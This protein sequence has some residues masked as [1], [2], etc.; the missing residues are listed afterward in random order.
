MAGY[1]NRVITKHFPELVEPGDDVWVTIRNPRLMPPGEL[2]S[3]ADDVET[4]PDGQP[5]NTGTAMKA[6]YRVGAKIIIGMRVYDPTA[7]IEL[8]DHGEPLPGGDEALLPA[9]PGP[10]DVAKLPLAIINWLGDEMAKINP[11]QTPESPGATG[12]PS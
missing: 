1:A 8:D 10:E 7:P 9:R 5:V 4:D 12:N 11:Q 2:S 6:T 3:A